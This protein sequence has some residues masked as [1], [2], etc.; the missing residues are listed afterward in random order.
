MTLLDARGRIFGRVNVIDAAAIL[1]VAAAIPAAAIGYRSLRGSAIEIARVEPSTLAEGEASRISLDGTGFRPYLQAYVAR[2]GQPFV[3]TQSDRLSQATKYLLSSAIRVELQLP[4]LAAGRY[5]LYLYDQGRQVAARPAALTIV[6]ARA[7]AKRAATVRF[8]LPPETSSLISRGDR[9]EPGGAVIVDVRRSEERSEV[10]EMHLVDQDTLWT[11]ARMTGQRV[12]ITL[13]VPV[14]EA[15]PGE[16][17][18]GGQR[19]L[20]GDVF[21]MTTDRYRLHGIVTWVG[22]PPPATGGR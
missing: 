10:M 5:D 1:V 20:A 15:S 12:E 17:T 21:L 19:V 22:D 13:E 18:Y 9:D 3:L 8:Y 4:A 16:W 11:G 2:S 14:A 7:G 6:P